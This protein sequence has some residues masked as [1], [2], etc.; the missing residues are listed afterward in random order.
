MVGASPVR[1]ATQGRERGGQHSQ[2]SL[3]YLHAWTPS[4][5]CLLCTLLRCLR[6]GSQGE[7]PGAS[8]MLTVL[9]TWQVHSPGSP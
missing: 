6:A 4:H 7:D 3:V 9:P 2:S 5:A 8:V 1:G